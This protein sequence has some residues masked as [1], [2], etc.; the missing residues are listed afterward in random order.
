MS[1]GLNI[2][3]SEFEGNIKDLSKILEKKLQK[4]IDVHRGTLKIDE[5]LSKSKVRDVLKL[6]LH[7]LEPRSYQV[8]SK[9]GSLK[10]KK[11]KSRSHRIKQRERTP[12]SAPQTLPY[13]FP[14]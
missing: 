10:I 4:K 11:T 8:I 2:D 12:P 13:F 1:V 3:A 6:A 14:R 9:S 5:K 7:K